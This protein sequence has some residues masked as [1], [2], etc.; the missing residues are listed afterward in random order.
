MGYLIYLGGG[1]RYG[2]DKA[3]IAAIVALIAGSVILMIFSAIAGS[4]LWG[5]VVGAAWG[6]VYGGGGYYNLYS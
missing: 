1:A 2:N 5:S 4:I 3:L 6:R